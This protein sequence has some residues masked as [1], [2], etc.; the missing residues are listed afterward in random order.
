M[1]AVIDSPVSSADEKALAS[2]GR[3]IGARLEKGPLTDDEAP[4][5]AMASIKSAISAPVSGSIG[6]AIA[7]A[8]LKAV[9]NVESGFSFKSVFNGSAL[10]LNKM[11]WAYKDNILTEGFT[12]IVGNRG[13][14]EEQ[15]ALARLGLDIAYKD[16][17]RKTMVNA[18]AAIMDAIAHPLSGPVAGIIANAVISADRMGDSFDCSLML[19]RGLDAI[20]QNPDIPEPVRTIAEEGKKA[21]PGDMIPDPIEERKAMLPFMKKIASVAGAEEEKEA[22]RRKAEKREELQNF[23]DECENNEHPTVDV[24]KEYV[25][26]DGIRLSRC[27][28]E[29]S[30]QGQEGVQS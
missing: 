27:S 26:I 16:G 6:I 7:G 5:K 2:L 18:R 22:E 28:T 11:R 21:D 12:S 9:E 23:I 25:H 3:A 13:A 20:S 10:E 30:L 14:T 15:R 17:Y 1:Q 29:E 24:E 4:A 8:V 19:Y